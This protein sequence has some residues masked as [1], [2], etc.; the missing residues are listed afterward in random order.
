MLASNV[1]NVETPGYRARELD[2][3]DALQ[4]AFEDRGATEQAPDRTPTVVADRLA[5]RRAD[6]STVD[7]DQQMAKLNAN[8]MTYLALARIL[9]RRV[10]LLRQAIDGTR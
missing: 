2:F 9:G 3:R 5:P 7:M 1:A 4:Q 6:G 8:G 10:A